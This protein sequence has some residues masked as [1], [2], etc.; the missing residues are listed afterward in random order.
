MKVSQ[1]RTR[2]DCSC[3]I[4]FLKNNSSVNLYL[5]EGIAG[6]RKHHRNFFFKSHGKI[7]GVSHTKNGEYFHLF[8]LSDTEIDMAVQI[9]AFLFH[10]FA[11]T[12]VFFGEKDGLENFLKNT[13]TRVLKKRE[14]FYMEVEKDHFIPSYQYICV[15]PSP[16]MADL[17]LPLQIQYEM[18]ELGVQR[19]EINSLRVKA[20]LRRRLERNEIT[21]LFQG[22][23]PIAI[24]AVNARFERSCQIGSVYVVPSYRG[25]GF[26]HSIVSGHIE[27]LFKTYDKIVLFVDIHNKRAIN[28]YINIG[29][30][31]AG[32]LEQVY[33]SSPM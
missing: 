33:V 31:I 30:Q 16:D 26:G 29:F 18:E 25:K 24:A 7:V 1:V 11:N 28:M 27:R 12:S 15:Q 23:E 20:A 6:Y 21:A 32:E 9:K 14:Y 13:R 17:L 4:N 5:Y 19:L 22:R 3:C 8:L 2:Y 10:R